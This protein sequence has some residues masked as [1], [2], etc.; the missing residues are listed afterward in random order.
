MK[1]QLILCINI[2]ILLE[3]KNTGFQDLFLFLQAIQITE[4][5]SSMSEPLEMRHLII[6]QLEASS[7]RRFVPYCN[8]CG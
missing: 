3:R 7:H 8:S 4:V 5:N 2:Y 6:I 1:Y